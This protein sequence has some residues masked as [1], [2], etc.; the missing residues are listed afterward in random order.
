MSDTMP[1]PLPQNW[2]TPAK[3]IFTDVDDTLTWEGRVPVET[4]SA[5]DQLQRAG[6]QV[7]PVTGGS[8][9]W[10]DCIVRTWPVDAIIV[11]NGAIW[12]HQD[13]KKHVHRNFVDAP[14]ARRDNLSRLKGLA[15][16]FHSIFPDIAFAEDQSFRLTDIAFDVAQQAD[17]PRERAREATQWW[18]DQGMKARLSSIH[19][20]VWAGQ[21]DK[22][23]T[24]V[25]WLK[26]N[27]S[28]DIEECVFVGDSANDAS[29]FEIFPHSV[30]VANIA[31]HLSE[32]DTQPRYITSMQGGYGFGELASRIL[33]L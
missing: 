25:A 31:K 3:I 24:A 32:M 19:I 13:D 5:L 9:G 4:F 15:E 1:M 23:T 8:A 26:A 17:V 29:M 7:V 22:A 2:P 27:T 6:I 30:G 28:V 33:E 14:D 16:L 10:G 11:E 20:N 21:H 18:I 12:L